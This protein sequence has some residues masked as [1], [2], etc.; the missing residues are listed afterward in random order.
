MVTAIDTFAK[1]NEELSD[2]EIQQETFAVLQE[3]YGPS[4]PPPVDI[5]VPRWSQDPLFRGSY[6][7]WPL[8]AL[9]Q[10]HENLRM[11]IGSGAGQSAQLHFSGEAMSEE[12]FGYV[13]G[14]WDEGL[15]TAAV[16]GGCLR[17]NDCRGPEVYEALTTCEQAETLLRKRDG[18]ARKRKGGMARRRHSGFGRH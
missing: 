8:G 16:I 2:G 6:S 9:D 11:P 10:H 4:I 15:N 13:Q 12:Y 7:N 17:D 1:R 3:I 14:A 5:L 18:K